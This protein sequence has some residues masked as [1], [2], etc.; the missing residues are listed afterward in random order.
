MRFV[1][2]IGTTLVAP[3]GRSDTGRL[4]ALVDQLDLSRYE[5]LIVSS[6]AIGSGGCRISRWRT[7]RLMFR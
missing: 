3:G 1:V 7:V 5:F 4:R 2:K 6:G